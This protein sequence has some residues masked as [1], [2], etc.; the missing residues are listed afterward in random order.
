MGGFEG[1]RGIAKPSTD[2]LVSISPGLR[3]PIVAQTS[4]NG[5]SV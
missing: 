4:E 1:W 3:G 2:S 5:F